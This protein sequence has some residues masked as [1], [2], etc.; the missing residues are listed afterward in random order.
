MTNRFFVLFFSLLL[1]VSCG[2]N[3]STEKCGD[4]TE[5]SPRNVI[6]LIGDG[7]GV[8]QVYAAMTAAGGGLAMSQ[9]PY[10]AFVKTFSANR[11]ITDSAAGGTALACGKKTDNGMLGVTPDTVAVE[12]L[13]EH[14][15]AL[16]YATGLVATSTIT[17]ATPASFYAHIA[18]RGEEDEIAVQL[19]NAG[20]DFFCGG[21]RNNFELR[22]DSV[23]L[24]DSLVE[25]G[26]SVHY[27]IDS[28]RAP[29]LLPA[30]ILAADGGMPAAEERGDFLP[31]ATDLA[32][33][34]LKAKAGN[35]GFFLMVEGSQIDWS[36]HGN[37]RWLRLQRCW[38]LT[39]Q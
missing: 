18:S 29:L 38:I 31:Q 13:L 20:V 36:C 19:V 25:R 2:R 4:V 35:K 28:L 39:R 6:L 33:K 9:M 17:H 10:T 5:H 32:I 30:A 34:S 15:K 37:D 11:Y 8:N 3:G 21:G 14:Y 16:G 12:S 22:A 23:V 24:T 1:L 7:M 27:S 26:Y